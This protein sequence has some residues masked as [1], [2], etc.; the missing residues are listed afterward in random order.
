MQ[1]CAAT[2]HTVFKDSG[3]QYNAESNEAG[4]SKTG[5]VV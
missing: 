1:H 3:V 2:S 5:D 4:H